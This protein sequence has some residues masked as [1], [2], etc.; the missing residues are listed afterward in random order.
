M[1]NPLNRPVVVEVPRKGVV[2]MAGSN[3]NGTADLLKGLAVFFMIQVHIM[4]QFASGEVFSSMTGRVSMFLGGPFCAP[5]FL[6]VMGYFLASGAKPFTYYLKRGIY[7][8]AGGILL[9]VLRSANLLVRIISGTV[10]LD[11][12][13]FVFGVDIL[14]LAG[15][16]LIVTGLL[17]KLFGNYAWLY[18]AAAIIL[19]AISPMISD[20]GNEK[21]VGNYLRAFI[22]GNRDW[23]YFPVFPWISYILTGFSFRLFLSNPLIAEKADQTKL[24]FFSIPV[25]IVLIITIPWASAIT[26]TLNGE[27]GYYHHGLLFFCWVILF[28]AAYLILVQ[29]VEKNYGDLL[30]FRLMK[31]SG[32]H[33]TLVYVVQWIIIGNLAANLYHTQGLFGYLTWFTGILAVSL[34]ISWAI[35]RIS[36]H[37][38]A[39]ATSGKSTGQTN[40]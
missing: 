10:E 40:Q 31:W 9:N 33:V 21:S 15:I 4:E 6:A 7:L 38:D 27:T 13:P 20:I 18:L 35:I 25:W 37:P 22:T 1:N 28:M 36:H 26:Y 16:S 19:A 11:P 17:R 24:Q 14:P 23:S 12:W 32:R 34:L 2:T 30:F 29:F 5:V 39:T 8:F 3:R